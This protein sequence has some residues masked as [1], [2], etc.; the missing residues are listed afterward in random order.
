M[1]YGVSSSDPLSVATA[2][3]VLFAIGFIACYVPARGA[4]R[5][6]PSVALREG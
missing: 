5:V 3:A 4:S 1:L 2:G 6:D